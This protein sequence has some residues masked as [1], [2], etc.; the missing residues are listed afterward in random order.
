MG[1]PVFGAALYPW[2]GPE[3]SIAKGGL[4]SG[5]IVEAEKRTKPQKGG[6]GEA[7]LDVLFDKADCNGGHSVPIHLLLFAVAAPPSDDAMMMYEDPALYGNAV[8]AS[9]AGGSGKVRSQRIQTDMNDRQDPGVIT[10]AVHAGQVTGV[11]HVE[12]EVGSGQNGSSRLHS[13]KVDFRIDPGATLVLVAPFKAGEHRR[14][15]RSC[16]N[17]NATTCYHASALTGCG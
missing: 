10:G 12:M 9:T 5:H 13:A 6:S 7:T 16:D 17:G 3:C 8:N 14:C 11:N 1:T 15:G 2:T 4:V